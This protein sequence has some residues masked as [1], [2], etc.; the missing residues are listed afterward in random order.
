VFCSLS[1][2]SQKKRQPLTSDDA[3]RTN[4]E[5]APLRDLFPQVRGMFQSFP[6]SLRSITTADLPAPITRTP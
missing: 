2:R 1:A 5:Q 6:G 4:S 3:G